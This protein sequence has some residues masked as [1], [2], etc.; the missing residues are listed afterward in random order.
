MTTGAAAE[1][2]SRA[3]RSADGELLPIVSR[4]DCFRGLATKPI[5]ELLADRLVRLL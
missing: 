5:S 3:V 4:S 1:P 2:S